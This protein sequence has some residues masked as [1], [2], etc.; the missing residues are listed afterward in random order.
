MDYELAATLPVF[1]ERGRAGR[2]AGLTN[3][4]LINTH[5]IMI[6]YVQK[7]AVRVLRILH[8]A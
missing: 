7:D 8:G 3:L 1:S 2:G 4:L 5:S 6:Y